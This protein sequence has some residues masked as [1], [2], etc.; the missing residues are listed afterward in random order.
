MVLLKLW[1]RRHGRYAHHRRRADAL[2]RFVGAAMAG[3]V[4]RVGVCGVGD[5]LRRVAAVVG[6]VRV[7]GRS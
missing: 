1:M 3:L 7:H 2:G 4:R 5:G 6:I